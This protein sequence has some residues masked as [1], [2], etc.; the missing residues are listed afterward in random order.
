VRAARCRS[1]VACSPDLH[2]HSK[3][4]RAT[5]RDCDLE[6]LYFWARRKGIRVVGTGDLTHPAWMAELRE[7]LVPA[8]PGL[9]R[10]RAS[11]SRR[12]SRASATWPPTGAPSGGV[13]RAGAR[14]DAL[15]LG[16]RVARLQVASK[17]PQPRVKRAS[18]P[19]SPS[20]SSSP[21]S[22]SSSGPSEFARP[23]FCAPSPRSREERKAACSPAT[24]GSRCGRRGVRRF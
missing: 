19:V 10:L 11:A 18:L 24:P 21:P 20:L 7:K 16:E 8:E 17:S 2:I 9:Y 23:R 6:H 3:Y 22:S 1:T 5:S 13:P 4:S 12:A 14:V 15:V